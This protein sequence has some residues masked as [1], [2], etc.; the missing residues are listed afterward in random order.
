MGTASF[1]ACLPSWE[2]IVDSW[3]QLQKLSNL[4]GNFSK[5]S[6]DLQTFS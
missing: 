3:I 2:D 4:D 1:S 5:D 6:L